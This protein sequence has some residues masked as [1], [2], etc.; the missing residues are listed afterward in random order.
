MTRRLLSHVP[1][2]R[3]L[4]LGVA[5]LATA[6]CGG[7]P[8]PLGS[9]PG[10]GGGGA[11]GVGGGESLEPLS[12][13]TFV[14]DRPHDDEPSLVTGSE[15]RWVD[16]MRVV[17]E[18]V[19]EGERIRLET[20]LGSWA[21]LV[22]NDSGTIDLGTTAPVDGSWSV[23]D[24][25]G[26]FWSAPP[27]SEPI[28]DVA[29]TVHSL[30]DDE[31]SATTSVYRKPLN[32]G[33]EITPLDDGTTVGAIARPNDIAP[34][35]QR[36]G[37]LVFGGSEGGTGS[38]QLQ[39]YYLAQLGYVAMGVGYF[40]APG[41]PDDL[42][43]VPLEILETDL[44]L[45]AAQPDV[46]PNRVAVMGGSRGGELALILGATFPQL[47]HAVVA[48]VPSGYVWGA[49]SGG[50]TSGWSHQGQDLPFLS[51]AGLFPES[52]IDDGEL[53]YRFTPFFQA[54]VDAATP[55]EREQATIAVEQTNG[56]I[57]LLGGKDDALWGS[58]ALSEVSFDRLT[59]HD[60][61]DEHPDAF[62]CLNGGHAAVGLVGLSTQN[63]EAFYSS[64]NQAWMDLGGTPATNGRARREANSLT[65]AFLE[66][67]LSFEETPGI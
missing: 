2:A 65:R 22:G 49:L 3:T 55:D 35:E 19:A 47:V 26:L 48:Q 21:E 66:K 32:V 29:I 27:S 24:V 33:I 13:V 7:D 54:A 51:T 9:T 50:G 15:M 11:S 38:G 41:L 12:I 43:R 10:S 18:G 25:D 39:A 4:V 56:P 28:F 6:A 20:S 60:H 61:Q 17:V 52:Y 46:D 1:L 37:V 67:A 57:L 23:A 8:S 62:H 5:S 34:G 16:E 40:G 42:D 63:S 31:R 36:P 58:C 53:H 44:E 59:E 64:F 30:D 45:L 14:D